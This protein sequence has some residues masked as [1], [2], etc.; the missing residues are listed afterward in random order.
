MTLTKRWILIAF[1]LLALI[2][3]SGCGGTYNWGW[4]VI[5]PTT[6]AGRN[7]LLFL[8]GGFGYTIALSLIAFVISIILGLAVALPGLS[9][10][11]WARACNR[12][13]VELFRAIPLLVLLLW[14]YYGLP[15]VLNINLDPFTASVIALAVGESAFQAEIFRAGVQSIERGQHEAADALGLGYLNKM[16][17]IILPQAI[18]RVLPPLANQFVYVLKMSALA[19]IIGMQELVR[20]ANELV[21]SAYRPLE[22]YTFLVLEYLVLVLIVS[23]LVRRLEQRMGA[24][25]SLGRAV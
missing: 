19:S 24:N 25:E 21:V 2:G 16:R 6:P 4:H 7:N 22:V 20:R 12:I 13:Y 1:A 5:L 17:Y 14:V 23:W 3:L 11:R 9:Q 10:K 18:R 8:L 15:V